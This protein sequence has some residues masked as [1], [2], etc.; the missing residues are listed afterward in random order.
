VIFKRA[1]MPTKEKTYTLTEAAREL[2]LTKQGVLNAI[3]KGRLP[4][5]RKEIVR[6][7]WMI[8]ADA[9]KAYKVSLTHQQSGKKN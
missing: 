2:G 7:I 3:D 8:K 5:E 1:T 4:A 6:K 9:V